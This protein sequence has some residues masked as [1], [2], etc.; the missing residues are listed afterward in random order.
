MGINKR[1][2]PHKKEFSFPSTTGDFA[3]AELVEVIT[4]NGEDVEQ[5]LTL[6]YAGNMGCNGSLLIVQENSSAEPWR[7][8]GRVLGVVTRN[9]YREVSAT[10]EP[11]V[12]NGE[13]MT[14]QACSGDD[15]SHFFNS[16][17]E[18]FIRGFCLVAVS[19]MGAAVANVSDKERVN[20]ALE[21]L[22]L[23]PDHALTFFSW[24]D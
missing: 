13:L 8:S 10:R 22:H 14:Y 20:L 9:G 5:H 19:D 12:I 15:L 24:Q 17:G 18:M 21:S 16:P 4:V 11:I 7:V 3:A 2:W 6:G 1:P 23:A